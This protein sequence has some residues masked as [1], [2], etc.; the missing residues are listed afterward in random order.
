MESLTVVLVGLETQATSAA[1]ALLLG[2]EYHVFRVAVPQ[3][4]G[5]TEITLQENGYSVERGAVR[6]DFEEVSAFVAALQQEDIIQTGNTSNWM[7]PLRLR[8]ASPTIRRGL[9]LLVPDSI[10]GLVENSRPSCPPWRIRRTLFLL[11]GQKL[12]QSLQGN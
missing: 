9:R 8:L 7:D 6:K 12:P 5:Y 3:R 11:P 10:R 1:L 4:V 2:Q